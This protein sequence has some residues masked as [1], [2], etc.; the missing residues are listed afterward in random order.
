MCLHHNRTMGLAR[1]TGL[2]PSTVM[3]L[4]FLTFS[5]HEKPRSVP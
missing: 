3:P 5:N 2:L 4:A 1:N